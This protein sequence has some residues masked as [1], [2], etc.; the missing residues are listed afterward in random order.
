MLCEKCKN[1]RPTVFF[2]DTGGLNHSLCASCASDFTLPLPS[3]PQPD[4][5]FYPEGIMQQT[6]MIIPCPYHVGAENIVCSICGST[7]SATSTHEP[8]RACCSASILG[9][10]GDTQK[11]PRRIR[12]ERDTK[13]K[14]AD[15]KR[16]LETYLSREEYERAAELRDKIRRLESENKSNKIKGDIQ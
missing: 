14:L 4:I 2:T 12:A 11:I 10:Y 3:E 8:V 5:I 9:A 15:L 13:K 6:A 1:R 16:R 7:Y